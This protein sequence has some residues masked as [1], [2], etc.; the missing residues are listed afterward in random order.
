MSD[1]IKLWKNFS[2][3]VF[4]FWVKNDPKVKQKY[5]KF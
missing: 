2:I 5:R 1:K 3:S 4:L